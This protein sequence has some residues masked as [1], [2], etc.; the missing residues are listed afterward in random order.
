M[1]Y[2]NEVESVVKLLYLGIVV[3]DCMVDLEI[4]FL[5]ELVLDHGSVAYQAPIMQHV[6]WNSIE[7]RDLHQIIPR[8]TKPM[9]KKR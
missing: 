3:R 1:L 2:D 4:E 5:T 8:S 7:G 9:Q 6:H